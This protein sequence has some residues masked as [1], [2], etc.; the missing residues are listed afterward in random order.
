LGLEHDRALLRGS[1]A[2]A[3]LAPGWG[4]I[5]GWRGCQDV[6]DR[7]FL[8]AIASISAY[9]RADARVKARTPV[10]LQRMRV[11]P[12]APRAQA[13]DR[14]VVCCGIV[15]GT[16]ATPVQ[17]LDM[18]P[19]ERLDRLVAL[20]PGHRLSRP[21][22]PLACVLARRFQ[23]L[24]PAVKRALVEPMLAA[25]FGASDPASTPR[26]HVSRPPRPSCFVLEVSC[27]HRRSSHARRNPIW[28]ASAQSNVSVW[29]LHMPQILTA[30]ADFQ[31]HGSSSSSRLIGC[32]STMRWSTSCRYA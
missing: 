11:Q 25:I 28:F 2:A 29:R 31:F 12:R 32:P 9:G 1:E 14:D 7:P 23:R 4:R 26:F 24:Q 18:H 16:H 30:F 19:P 3:T 10:D 22:A 20:V 8:S 5:D 21:L 6:F 13:V 15:F 17:C 27:P